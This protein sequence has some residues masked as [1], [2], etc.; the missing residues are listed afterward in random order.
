MARQD[1]A[2]IDVDEFGR[3]T[4]K[5]IQV[6][7]EGADE[8]IWLPVSAVTEICREPADGKPFVRVEKWL[9]AKKGLL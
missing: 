6:K 9:A 2:R 3:D 1:T 7:P 8:F 5:A 4:D